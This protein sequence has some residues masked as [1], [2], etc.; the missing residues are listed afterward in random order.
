MVK[1]HW[2]K[3][4]QELPPESERLLTLQSWDTASKGGPDNDWS[5]CTTWLVT[6]DRR[7]YLLDVWRRRVDYP[8]LKTAVE[9]LAMQWDASACSSKTPALGP[10]SF[11][12]CEERSRASSP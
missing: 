7:W 5:V 12:N 8:A 10:R 9:T 1:R 6:H 11:R 2:V 4:Y 3:R